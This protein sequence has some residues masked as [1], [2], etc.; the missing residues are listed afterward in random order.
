M[1]YAKPDKLPPAPCESDAAAA[2]ERHQLI[3]SLHPLDLCLVDQHPTF[4]KK[5]VKNFFALRLGLKLIQKI[6]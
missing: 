2:N 6:Q 1:E 3:R 5:A 4:L